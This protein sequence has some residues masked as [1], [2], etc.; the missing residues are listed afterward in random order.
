MKT[1]KN[2]KQMSERV[3]YF[4]LLWSA[5]AFQSWLK[6]PTSKLFIKSCI[7]DER[8][9]NDEHP[10]MVGKQTWG[11]PKKSVLTSTPCLI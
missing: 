3:K 5:Q 1:S 7:L 2:K 8:N 6:Y 9:R 10:G 4:D 11:P